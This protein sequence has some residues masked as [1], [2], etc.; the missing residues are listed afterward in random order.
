VALRDDNSIDEANSGAALSNILPALRLG[1]IAR[2]V[3]DIAAATIGLVLF[4][5]LLLIAFVAI[6]LD[7]PGPVL[8]RETRY[9]YK[10][11]PIQVLKFRLARVCAKSDRIN[12]RLTRVGRI[13]SQTC[14]DELPGLVNV[15]RGELSVM[16]PPPSA[17]LKTSLNRIKPGMISWTQ[18]VTARDRDP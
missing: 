10:N 8:V 14:I 16:G 2:R 17:H 15:L 1:H 9:G 18:I 7:S 5:P 12:S 6:R 13:L 3:V 4:S 11:R